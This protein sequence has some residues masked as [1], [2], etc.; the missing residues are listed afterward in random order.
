[1]VDRV[2]DGVVDDWGGARCGSGSLVVNGFFR[3]ELKEETELAFRET[4][5]FRKT[6]RNKQVHTEDYSFYLYIYI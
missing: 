2:V 6:K 4:D 3:L 5:C 1:M